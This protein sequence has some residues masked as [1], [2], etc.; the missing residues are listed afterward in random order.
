MT[1]PTMAEKT[2]LQVTITTKDANGAVDANA[3]LFVP[4]K[5]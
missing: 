5:K 3:I 4:E 2:V 1:T